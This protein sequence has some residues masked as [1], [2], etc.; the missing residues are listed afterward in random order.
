MLPFQK[1][2]SLPLKVAKPFLYLRCKKDNK[3]KEND[4]ST[5]GST[6]QSLDSPHHHPN[7]RAGW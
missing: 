7:P 6:L 4:E 3:G 2:P 5:S 1:K